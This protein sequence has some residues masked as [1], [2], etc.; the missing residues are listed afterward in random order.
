MR[1][2]FI[3]L[4]IKWFWYNYTRS[5]HLFLMWSRVQCYLNDG[6]YYLLTAWVPLV[7]DG[8]IKVRICWIQTWVTLLGTVTDSM[9]AAVTARAAA[10]MP[11]A[12]C[13]A[14]SPTQTAAN[15]IQPQLSS[16]SNK[17]ATTVQALIPACLYINHNLTLNLNIIPFVILEL[18]ITL[19]WMS[20]PNLERKPI[21]IRRCFPNGNL[22]LRSWFIFFTLKLFLIALY[23]FLLFMCN[24]QCKSRCM[25]PRKLTLKPIWQLNSC[26]R[27]QWLWKRSWTHNTSVLNSSSISKITQ[28]ISDLYSP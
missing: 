18:N 6:S 13:V 3:K 8:N 19:P 28:E 17:T 16:V 24:R 2:I 10:S 15:T 7:F 4:T 5:L 20:R 1:L 14:S 27:F 22:M 12:T 11:A 21:R 23:L 26:L 9:A 25:S